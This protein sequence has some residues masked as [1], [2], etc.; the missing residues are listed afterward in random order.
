M[1]SFITDYRQEEPPTANIIN[2]KS[3]ELSETPT[4]GLAI[5][6][7]A[8]PL[9]RSR[10]TGM[11][12]FDHLTHGIKSIKAS[13]DFD[14]SPVVFLATNEAESD[15][16]IL[17]R[18]QHYRDRQLETFG[19]H[20]G[21]LDSFDLKNHQ[22][23]WRLAPEHFQKRAD[24]IPRDNRSILSE[25]GVYAFTCE[26]TG[27]PTRGTFKPYEN[28]NWHLALGLETRGR[29]CLMFWEFT[30]DRRENPVR[31]MVELVE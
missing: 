31:N 24:L 13:F 27:E 23:N 7:W 21:M 28:Q 26:S 9:M 17:V 6:V 25:K 30:I 14:F 1:G 3:T 16:Q 22:R 8:M 19:E 4:S 20:G 29:D 18:K 11:I 2:G 12:V 5:G 10:A 15:P